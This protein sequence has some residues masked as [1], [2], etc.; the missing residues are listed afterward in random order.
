[1]RSQCRILLATCCLLAGCG[2]DGGGTGSV[3]PAPAPVNQAPVFSSPSTATVAENTATDFYQATAAD[4]NNDPVSFTISGTDAARFT[5]SSSGQLRFTSPPNF[6]APT[7]A[8]GDNV[9]Q[10]VVTASDGRLTTDMALSITVGN[11]PDETTLVQVGGV[12]TSEVRAI[13]PVP[14]AKLIFVGQADGTIRIVDP[15]TRDL[16]GVYL[17]VAGSTLLLGVTAAP[18][19]VTSGR[20]YVTLLNAAG[21]LE[22]R[23]YGRSSAATGDAASADLIFRLPSVGFAGGAPP[24]VT[25][26]S[27]TFGPDGL[28]YLTTPSTV[29]D[30]RVSPDNLYGKVLRIDVARDDFPADAER[31]YGIPAANPFAGRSNGREVFATGFRDPRRASFDGNVLFVG[32]QM[33][34]ADSEIDLVRPEDAGKSY[35]WDG[36]APVLRLSPQRISQRSLVLGGNV[37]RGPAPDLAGQ[38]IFYAAVTPEGLKSIPAAS[39]VQGTTRTIA[40]VASRREGGVSAIGEDA[41]RNFYFS[42]GGSIFVYRYS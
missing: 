38:Y 34:T 24:A 5:L 31:D 30:Q 4:P 21:D 8:N 7:D 42:A 41:D 37:Y 11:V 3:P 6:E 2:G 26:G 22:L 18:D 39:L 10:V 14:G 16:G 27:I 20:L 9:Y 33:D 29:E 35:G 40:D 13:A 25:G 19:Y 1:M 12:Y 17:T 32:D 28:L 36:I 15:A 23:R